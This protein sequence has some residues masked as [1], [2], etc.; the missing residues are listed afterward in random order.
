MRR[1]EYQDERSHK[2]WAITV[3]GAELL[4]QW[5]RMGT[6]GQQ[7]TKAFADGAAAQK[8][9]DKLIRQ[10]TKKGYVEVSSGSEPAGQAQTATTARGVRH[11][12]RPEVSGTW[13]GTWLGSTRLLEPAR[14]VR[15]LVGFNPSLGTVCP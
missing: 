8:E 3:E 14:G 4:T 12:V 2:F 7:K 10:K 1:F 11:L 13:L 5:G 15:H 6:T 9:A